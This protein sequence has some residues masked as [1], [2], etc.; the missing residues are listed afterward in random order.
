[1]IVDEMCEKNEV[2]FD[3]LINLFIE[4]LDIDDEFVIL[5]INEG[6]LIFEEVV[7]VLVLE[8]LEIDGLDEEI[9]D[10]LCLCVKDVLIIKVFKIEESFEGVEFVEDL[11]VFEGF[12]CYFVFVMVSKGVVILEDLVE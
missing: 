3:K 8:F 1:M 12:E 7:Y 10:I 2:E 6:F 4:Y 11:F 5:F 9:V